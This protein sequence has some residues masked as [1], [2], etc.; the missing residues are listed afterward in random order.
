MI[1]NTLKC[2]H[3]LISWHAWVAQHF[4]TCHLS[5]GAKEL[6]PWWWGR[7]QLK[8][9][10]GQAAVFPIF[11][12]III[13]I[14]FFWL[15]SLYTVRWWTG[16]AHLNQR[17][18]IQGKASAVLQGELEQMLGSDVLHSIRH[19]PCLISTS[20]FCRRQRETRWLRWSKRLRRAGKEN[21]CM[22]AFTAQPVLLHWELL[23]VLHVELTLQSSQQPLLH[24]NLPFNGLSGSEP[25]ATWTVLATTSIFPSSLSS[26]AAIERNEHRV[27]LL[28][29]A[30]VPNLRLLLQC[31]GRFPQ[32][33]R[34]QWQEYLPQKRKACGRE[35][36]MC[37]AGH[38]K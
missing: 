11:I 10:V 27:E 38:Q 13:I 22:T 34:E 20:L 12:F 25:H 18:C 16:G 23:I 1:L 26:H 37:W 21:L 33:G 31:L 35:K 17:A 28:T 19:F 24:L 4:F 29:L 14:T 30:V 7:T 36:K 3:L 8:E 15:A 32:K 6:C 2:N 9:V 5:T